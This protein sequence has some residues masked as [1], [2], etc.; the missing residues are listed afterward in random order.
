VPGLRETVTITRQRVLDAFHEQ[1]GLPRS[2]LDQQQTLDPAAVRAKLTERF[3]GQRHA[4]QAAVEIVGIAK[5]RLNDPGRP[6]ASLLLLGPTGVGKTEFAKSLATYLFGHADRLLRFDMNEYVSALAVPQ[7][8][9][10]F[11]QPEGL[12]T[13]AVRRQPFA[14]VLFDE[15]EKGHP[16][17]FDLLLQVLGEGRLTDALGRT[18]DFSNTIV[19]LTSNLG[20]RRSEVGL[21]FAATDSSDAQH[22]LQAARNFFRPEFFNRLDRV[23]PFE[24]LGRDDLQHIARHL[25]AD[26]LQRDGLVRRRG[27]LHVATPALDWVLEQGHNPVLGARALKRAIER[28]LTRPLARYLAATGARREGFDGPSP[29]AGLTLIEVDRAPAE[30]LSVAVRELRPHTPAPGTIGGFAALAPSEMLVRCAALRERLAKTLPVLRP[31]EPLQ[32]GRPSP[33]QARYFTLQEELSRLGRWLDELQQ[34]VQAERAVTVSGSAQVKTHRPPSA[35]IRHRGPTHSSLAADEGAEDA[36]QEYL[37]APSGLPSRAVDIPVETRQVLREL[38]WLDAL[39]G[40]EEARLD[41][42]VSLCVRAL[43]RLCEPHAQQLAQRLVDAWSHAGLDAA[44][45]PSDDAG[46]TIRLRGPLARQFAD[47]EAGFHALQAGAGEAS[48]LLSVQVAAEPIPDRLVRTVVATAQRPHEPFPS[49]DQLLAH[50]WDTLPLPG[51]I[52]E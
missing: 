36:I 7:L 32:A 12:L 22:A 35:L 46:Q 39:A 44:L 18:T 14:V 21:G 40:A 47:A 33:R 49:I 50:A 43:D 28:E 10:T 27:V 37:A 23:I 3:V 8:V 6:M 45:S 38:A 24:R 41:E 20:T 26:V 4:V 13:A 9:G 51:E 2:F 15:I 30:E 16:D 25:M 1:S 11:A 17:V 48:R 19:I 31:Q 5:A 29:S 42:Q 52:R 34:A